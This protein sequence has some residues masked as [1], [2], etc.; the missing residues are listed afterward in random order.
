MNIVVLVK[1]TLIEFEQGKSRYQVL[2]HVYL[3]KIEVGFRE[4]KYMHCKPS[5]IV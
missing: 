5:K 1:N 3:E 2:C 4:I